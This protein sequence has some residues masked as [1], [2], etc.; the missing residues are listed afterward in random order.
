MPPGPPPHHTAPIH[1]CTVQYAHGTALWL[2]YYSTQAQGSLN[3][4]YRPRRR[5]GAVVLVRGQVAA[6]HGPTH[7]LTAQLHLH[8]TNKACVCTVR[9]KHKVVGSAE[10]EQAK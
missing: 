7:Q 3:A 1:A 9:T 5:P 2:Q 8:T 6:P 10:L 4:V